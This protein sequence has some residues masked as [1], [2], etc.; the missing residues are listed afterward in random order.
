LKN[1]FT[2]DNSNTTTNGFGLK[3][4]DFARGLVAFDGL[5]SNKSTALQASITRNSTDQ[6]RVTDRASRVESQLYKQYSALDAQMAKMNA[7]S[8]YVTAQLSVWTNSK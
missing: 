7:L 4:R 5:V 6:E 8:S 3:V 1:L 2:A